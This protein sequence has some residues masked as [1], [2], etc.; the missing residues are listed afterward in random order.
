M[1]WLK[2]ITFSIL[3]LATVLPVVSFGQSL[4]LPD[5]TGTTTE[6]TT[7]A[8]TDIQKRLGEMVATG[9]QAVAVLALLPIAIG[10]IQLI[11]SQGNSDKVEK[12]KKTLLWGVLGLLAALSGVAVFTVLLS[13]LSK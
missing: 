2:I 13:V 10:G 3:L 7:D 6:E 1:T 5:Y 4:P 12:G 9:L 11:I 8:V